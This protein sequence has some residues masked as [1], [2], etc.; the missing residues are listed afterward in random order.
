MNHM[1]N[2]AVPEP[3]VPFG[4]KTGWLCVRS[5][6]PQAVMAA[7][8]LYGVPCGWTAGLERGRKDGAVFVS[9]VL[10]DFVLVIGWITE[11]LDELA[12]LAEKFP[13]MQYYASHRVVE[14]CAWASFRAGEL[15]RAY[16][17]VGDQGEVPWDEGALTPEE[18]ALGGESFPRQDEEPD[19]DSIE[20]PNEET[21]LSLAA[22]W[23]I[24]P[25]FSKKQY[26]ASVGWLC[27]QAERP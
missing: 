3:P 18:T 14:Y 22:A 25:T 2:M 26:P 9:P 24:D 12:A 1:E 8:G 21:V 19:W 20:Y 15:F 23:G 5:E 6:D 17:Y 16:A 13:E 7:L 10:D 11:E 4:Y 27:R